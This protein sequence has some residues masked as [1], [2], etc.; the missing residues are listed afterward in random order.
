[1]GPI[2]FVVVVF[3]GLGSL[4]GCFIASLIMGFVQTFAVVLEYS[5]AD[6]LGALGMT[7]S[8]ATPAAR[9]PDHPAAPDRRAPAV[10]DAGAHPAVQAPR[11]HG[12][13]RHVSA[14]P[15]S[16]AGSAV[17]AREAG[18]LVR[19]HWPWVAAIAVALLV[20]WLFF[21]WTKGRHSG[22]VVTMLSQ[23]GMMVV[24]AL[25][26]NMQMG[27]AGLLSFGHAVFF[28]L[29]AYCT[30]HVVNAIKAGGLW[31]PM[32]LVPL[33]GGLG[34]LGFAILFGYPAT[35]Q[36]ATAFAMITLGIGELVT[37]LR[38]HVQDVLRRRGGRQHQ[39]DD[40]DQ[41]ARAELR[42]A[43]PGL[44][45]D[46]GVDRAVRLADAAPDPHAARAHGQCLPRQLRAGAVRRLR[47][48]PGALLPVRALRLLRGDRRAPCTPSPTRS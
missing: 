38:P 29:G 6:L 24:F 3:G 21:D 46:R 48:E 23:M 1:M 28:G 7:V 5:L 20:P 19:R 33:V 4:A 2:V 47:P 31:L 11:P 16:T 25:S 26:Y 37:A 30:A 14:R 41:P 40:G 10:P 45:P 15:L 13:A 8:E 44:L 27:Q 17:A 12:D 9:V 18:G 32:E 34:G 36:R 42:P 35:K 39:P 43:D 22:F